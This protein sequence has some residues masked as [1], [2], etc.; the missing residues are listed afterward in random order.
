MKMVNQ[1]A[2]DFKGS[3]SGRSDKQHWSSKVSFAAVTIIIIEIVWK[4]FNSKQHVFVCKSI[5]SEKGDVALTQRLSNIIFANN[6]VANL[7]HSVIWS[8]KCKL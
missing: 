6:C 7:P 4:M 1:S 8:S 2:I 3:A 5:I